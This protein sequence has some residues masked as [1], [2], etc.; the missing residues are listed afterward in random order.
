MEGRVMSMTFK[1][2]DAADHLRD[3]ADIAAYLEAAGEFDDPATTVAALATVARA[4]NMS[5]LARDADLTREGLRKALSAEGNPSFAT[6]SK[7]AKALGIRV[8]LT[9]VA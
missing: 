3:E 2:F 9:P 6:V 4:R 1:R 8:V 5:A 7:I